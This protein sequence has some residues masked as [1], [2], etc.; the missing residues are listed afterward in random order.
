[1]RSSKLKELKSYLEEL[2]VVQKHIIPGPSKFISV[3]N[4][5][6]VLNNGMVIRREK[7]LKAGKDGSAVIVVPI[8]ENGEVLTVVEPRVF[9]KETVSVGFPA[10]Y[11][12]EGEN[13][14][15]SAKRELFEET[16]Y[17]SRDIIKIDSFY[18]DEGVSGAYNY[19]FLA[20]DAVKTGDQHLDEG[21]IV[22]YM[23]FLPDE[24]L[25][26]EEMG[27]INSSNIKLA[28]KGSLPYLKK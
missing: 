1:M 9:T 24:L 7:L 20:R 5:E 15:I 17:D 4:Y 18:Q 26:L 25:E 28:L 11:V 19:I 6:C 23:S 10:G 12:E 27:Y 14:I 8:L 22:R 2:K 3:E 16:G 13:P 21:E